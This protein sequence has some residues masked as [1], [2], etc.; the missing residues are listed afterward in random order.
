MT[1]LLGHIPEVGETV[2]V[3]T[4]LFKVLETDN[5]S[6]TKIA[7]QVLPADEPETT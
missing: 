2:Q 1:E 3:E 5:Q 7:L 4:F 6:V